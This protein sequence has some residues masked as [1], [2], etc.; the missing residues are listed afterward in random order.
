[1]K[2]L[3]ITH[4]CSWSYGVGVGY[5]KGMTYDNYMKIAWDHH[6][7]DEFSFRG[8][9]SNTL[10]M[11]NLNFA[12]GGSSNQ[13]QFRLAKEFF[14]SN[15]YKELVKQ[16][17]EIIILWCITST[18][19]NEMFFTENNDFVNFKY[20]SGKYDVNIKDN[21]LLKAILKYSYNHD[22]EVK[23]LS[24]NMHFWTDYIEAHNHKII[25]AD[26][27][28]HHNYP[29]YPINLIDGDKTEQRDFLSLLLNTTMLSRHVDKY[30]LSSW[31][32]DMDGILCD[33]SDM[34]ILNPHTF[35][36]TKLGH[37]IIAEYLLSYIDK[38]VCR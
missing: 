37:K 3:L 35:H 34:G 1:M 38:N 16:Y 11:D 32:D 29:T 21:S 15:T 27:F 9:L 30:H 18:F 25:W 23:Q 24:I 13:R 17:D 4:G 7:N 22:N 28:N 10:N 5:E 14:I 36:P 6:I 33:L 31:N 2:R 8:I 19:R 26:T 20:D 12:G